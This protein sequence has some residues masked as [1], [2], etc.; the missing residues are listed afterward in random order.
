MKPMSLTG[1]QD[2][3]AGENEAPIRRKNEDLKNESRKFRAPED[4][5]YAPQ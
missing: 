1:S 3:I 4:V 2:K 5:G